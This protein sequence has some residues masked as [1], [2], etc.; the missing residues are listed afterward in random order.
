MIR[1]FKIVIFISLFVGL[2][3]Y[4]VMAGNLDIFKI[5]DTVP[6]KNVN[7]NKLL[8]AAMEWMQKEKDMKLLRSNPE[9]FVVEGKGFL[10]YYNHVVME[11]VFLSPRAGERTNGTIVYAVKVQ[12]LDSIVTVEY[13]NFVHDAYFSEFGKISLGQ[14]Y[15]YDNVPPG[16]CME[17]KLWCNKVWKEMKTRSVADVKDHSIRVVPDEYIRKK[18]KVFK[19]EKE[20]KKQEEKKENPEDYLKLDSYLNQDNADTTKAMI[21]K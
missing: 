10:L 19:V 4:T 5:T 13:S 11:D 3:S 14:L 1:I 9:E 21:I 15:T 12:I 18:G 6:I 16:K 8:K 17:N 7:K 20:V 2:C